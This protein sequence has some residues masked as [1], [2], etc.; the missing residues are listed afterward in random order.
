MLLSPLAAAARRLQHVAQ[1]A[2]HVSQVSDLLAQRL[3]GAGPLAV[4]FV[5]LLLELGQL[6]P[7]GLD[8][9]VDGLLPHREVD[10]AELVAGLDL[11]QQL[12]AV[13]LDHIR[14]DALELGAEAGSGILKLLG[15]G[16]VL[17][18]L[19]LQ[20]GEIGV[21]L[22]EFGPN[23]ISL[24]AYLIQLPAALLQPGVER[25]HLASGT[26]AARRSRS[27]SASPVGRHRGADDS[28]R[29]H[30]EDCDQCCG[31]HGHEGT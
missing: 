11:L 6:L 21:G 14:G 20:L 7:D 27:V 16:P 25:R 10:F 15:A 29:G 3:V 23:A 30:G 24:R 19:G 1:P 8:H 22:A 28:G 26:S 9:S 17:G 13:A 12:L 31:F 2:C 5:D 4:E 18:F